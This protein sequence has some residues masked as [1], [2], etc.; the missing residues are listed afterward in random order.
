MTRPAE[1]RA[2]LGEARETLVLLVRD[3]PQEAFVRP[4][5]QA[6]SDDERWP[7]REVL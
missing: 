2:R 1:L 5:A 7:I 4:P 3:L 6:S